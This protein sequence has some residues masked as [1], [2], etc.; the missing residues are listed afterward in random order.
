MLQT[1]HIP[2]SKK[3][4]GLNVNSTHFF[5]IDLR[6]VRGV[7]EQEAKGEPSVKLLTFKTG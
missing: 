4:C 7:P 2:F 3:D 6:E 1:R 5:C